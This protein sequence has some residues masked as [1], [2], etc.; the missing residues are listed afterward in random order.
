MF[1]FL[2]KL[3]RNNLNK[4]SKGRTLLLQK[5]ISI[6]SKHIN[7]LLN[8]TIKTSIKWLLVIR[9]VFK[10][11]NK[12]NK[13]L[14]FSVTNCKLN[15]KKS[16]LKKYK[17]RPFLSKLK[18]P[19]KKLI[20]FKKLLLLKRN[21]LMLKVL[22]LNWK[23]RRHK[24]FLNKQ[25]L[26]FLKQRKLSVSLTLKN[27][28]HSNLFRNHQIKSHNWVS[29]FFTWDLQELK[30]KKEVGMK[31]EEWYQIHL[32]SSTHLNSSVNVLVK[33]QTDKSK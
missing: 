21:N 12:P 2:F 33:L 28:Q 10:N 15:K 1:I 5:I 32:H 6:S 7:Y 4:N 17:S 3:T 27:L 22:K 26:K 25:N 20:N 18:S 31:S 29:Q 14:L 24:K 23:A 16:M 30:M 19:L 8:L 9:M 11:S 13:L